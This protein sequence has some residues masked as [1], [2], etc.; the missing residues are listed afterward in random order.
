MC[1]GRKH[2]QW[3]NPTTQGS[4]NPKGLTAGFR[5]NFHPHDFERN[6]TSTWLLMQLHRPLPFAT[7]AVMSQLG[8]RGGGG[9]GGNSHLQ[10]SLCQNETWKAVS[11]TSCTWAQSLQS[12]EFPPEGRH[13]D[14]QH[15]STIFF[16]PLSERRTCAVWANAHDVWW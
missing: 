1:L 10:V 9:G 13:T 15:S 11:F 2:V 4:H 16:Y 14:S 8:V 6:R 5:E 7:L 12:R 3:H